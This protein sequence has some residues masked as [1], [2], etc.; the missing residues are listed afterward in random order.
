MGDNGQLYVPEELV[1]IY[2]DEVVPLATVLT[3]NQFEAETLTG[4]KIESDKDAV[5]FKF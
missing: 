4:M 3:P 1:P 5:S 2:R